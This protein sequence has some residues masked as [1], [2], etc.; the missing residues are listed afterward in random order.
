MILVILKGPEDDVAGDDEERDEVR[1][2]IVSNVLK[3]HYNT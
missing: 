3:I 1:W 2:C